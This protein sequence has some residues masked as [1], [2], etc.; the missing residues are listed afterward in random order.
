M[1]TVACA[2]VSLSSHQRLMEQVG[3]QLKL[4]RK[5][6]K[7]TMNQVAERAGISRTTLFL[8]EKGDAAVAIGSYFN[9]LRTLGLAEDILKLGADDEFGQKLRD[10]ELL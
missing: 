9:V 5:R 6:R 8:I 7:L 10:L 2:I 4:A 3:E 1:K